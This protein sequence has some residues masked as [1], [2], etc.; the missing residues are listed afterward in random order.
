MHAVFKRDLISRW[1]K[2]IADKMKQLRSLRTTVSSKK[3]RDR[4][5]QRALLFQYAFL[6]SSCVSLSFLIS[7]GVLPFAVILGRKER[8]AALCFMGKLMKYS[9]AAAG[10][11]QLWTSC[12]IQP[13]KRMRGEHDKESGYR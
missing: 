5:P 10:S 1:S 12:R 11:A 6:P 3:I 2:G 4:T 7:A 8:C 13:P 9:E